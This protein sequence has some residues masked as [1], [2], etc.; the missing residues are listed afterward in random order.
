[1]TVLAWTLVFAALVVAALVVPAVG[2]WRV[3]TKIR[4]VAAVLEEANA[5]FARAQG[6]VTDRPLAPLRPPALADPVRARDEAYAI[7]SQV[8]SQR[9]DRRRARTRAALARWRAAGII[10]AEPRR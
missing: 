8:R 6:A 4:G 10:S 1:M 3:W 9:A 2:V 7:R 5:G